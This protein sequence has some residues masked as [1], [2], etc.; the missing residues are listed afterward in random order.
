[1]WPQVEGEA[2]RARNLGKVGRNDANLLQ[3][4][5]AL[6]PAQ[7]GS[8]TLVRAV[9]RL[10]ARRASPSTWGDTLWPAAQAQDAS[11]VGPHAPACCAG[12]RTGTPCARRP[13]RLSALDPSAVCSTAVW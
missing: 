8:I 12:P 3:Q 5:A 4:V 2:R 1:M 7:A 6:P 11:T 13:R 9:P 10:R